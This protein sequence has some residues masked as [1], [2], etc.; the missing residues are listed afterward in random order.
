ML[1]QLRREA[2]GFGALEQMAKVEPLRCKTDRARPRAGNP[3]GPQHP[4]QA[5][6]FGVVATASSRQRL[7]PL[8]RRRV[9]EL[10]DQAIRRALGLLGKCRRRQQTGQGNDGE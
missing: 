9:A 7:R 3:H 6:A 1:A 8:M 2:L 10:D 4:L 5:A